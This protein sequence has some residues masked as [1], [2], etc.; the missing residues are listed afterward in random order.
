MSMSRLKKLKHKFWKRDKEWRRIKFD[1][2]VKGYQKLTLITAILGLVILVPIVAGYAYF[3]SLIGFPILGLFLGGL[4]LHVFLLIVVNVA[5]L[6]VAFR[7]KKTK[8]AGILLVICGLVIFGSTTLLGIPAFILFCIA[9]V[10]ALKEKAIFSN[11][12]QKKGI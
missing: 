2:K 11:A 9:G 4:L 7:I 10:L 8:V 5:S 1:E 6:Y 3:N 12:I